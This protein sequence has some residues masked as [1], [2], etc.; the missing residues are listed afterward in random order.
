M[1]DET[2]VVRPRPSKPREAESWNGALASQQAVVRW[3]QAVFALTQEITE[4]TQHRLQ[5]DMAAWFELA[6]CRSGEQAM[7]C[8]QRFASKAAQQYSDEIT[9]LTRMVT[10]LAWPESREQPRAEV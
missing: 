10:S 9:K 7:E 2:K 3:T 1:P 4:F 6:A 8:Q 5:E